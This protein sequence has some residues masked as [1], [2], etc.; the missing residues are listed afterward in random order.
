MSL[1]ENFRRYKSHLKEYSSGLVEAEMSDIVKM[2]AFYDTIVHNMIH[3]Q[4]KDTE[5]WV[6]SEIK[7]DTPRRPEKIIIN[8]VNKQTAFDLH[9]KH[10][11]LTKE[12]NRLCE[13]TS[14]WPWKSNQVGL[15]HSITNKRVEL[16]ELEEKMKNIF[17]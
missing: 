13:A 10:E 16:H 7:K 8:D 2:S 17:I 4:L 6:R 9:N 15:E 5:R 11:K 14:A 12:L 3:E 1:E